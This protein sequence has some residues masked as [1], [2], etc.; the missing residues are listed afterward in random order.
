[1]GFS[2]VVCGLLSVVPSHH[3]AQYKQHTT[4]QFSVLA[5]PFE[6]ILATETSKFIGNRN[7]VSLDF[8]LQVFM[9]HLLK[10]RIAGGR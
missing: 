4:S 8:R 6:A 10:A 9:L 7:L 1:M 3:A 2:F 5:P